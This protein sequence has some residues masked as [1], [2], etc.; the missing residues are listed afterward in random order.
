MSSERTHCE[1]CGRFASSGMR[2]VGEPPLCGDCKE[3]ENTKKKLENCKARL[4]E[5]AGPDERSWRI[6]IKEQ[7]HTMGSLAKAR[8]KVEKLLDLGLWY[9]ELE[10]A[11]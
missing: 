6:R 4:K 10:E 2:P 1:R 5:F 7:T 11:K 8:E 9:L 3:L